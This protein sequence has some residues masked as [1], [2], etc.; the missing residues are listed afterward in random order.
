MGVAFS[1]KA[2]L[3]YGP[4]GTI[5]IWDAADPVLYSEHALERA[6][7]KGFPLLGHSDDADGLVLIHHVSPPAD[8]AFSPDGR[9]IASSAR[10]DN[11]A[12]FQVIIR[13]LVTRQEACRIATPPAA[14]RDLSFSVDGRALAVLLH[15]QSGKESKTELRIYDSNSG[16]LTWSVDGP[17]AKGTALFL[18]PF[19][20]QFEA[21][22]RV[23]D[24]ETI[25]VRHDPAT[26]REAHRVKVAAP[27]LQPL[28]FAGG[29]R[30]FGAKPQPATG[31]LQLFEFNPDSGV[32]IRCWSSGA[33]NLTARAASTRFLATSHS[34]GGPA[35]IALWDIETGRLV[36][37]L[38]GSVGTITGLAFS[39]DGERLLSC[40]T[41]FAARV[42]DT[43]SGREL[44]TLSNHGD[45]VLK[46]AWSQDGERIATASLDGAVRVWSAGGSRKLPAIEPWELLSPA[47]GT[48]LDPKQFLTV[49]LGDW[50]LE[51]DDLI[52]TLRDLKDKGFAITEAK[53]PT[54]DLPRTVDIQC[55]VEVSR[56]M[57]IAIS[58]NNPM[59]G[60]GYTPFVAGT[61]QPFGP[62]ARL[63]VS[64]KKSTQPFAL[65]G[66]ARS[67][68]LE[69]NRPYR[70]RVLRQEGRLRLFVDEQ[71]L[72]DEKVPEIDLPELS[73]QGSWSTAGDEIRFSRII[74]RAPGSAVRERKLRARLDR[75][76]AEELLPGPVRD[77]LMAEKGLR[78]SE[79]QTLLAALATLPSDA[80]A[81]RASA[82]SLATKDGAAQAE[83]ER[84]ARQ[85]KAVVEMSGIQFANPTQGSVGDL[86][87]LSLVEHRLG[88]PE[89]AAEILFPLLEFVRRRQG[90]N[91]L[92][93]LALAGLVENSRGR[94]DSAS[95][96]LQRLRDLDR[97]EAKWGDSAQPL[98][99]EA[100]LLA[101]RL[102]VLDPAREGVKEAFLQTENAGWLR[103]EIGIYFAGRTPDCIDIDQR[104]DKPG[105]HDLKLT[106]AV[107]RARRALQF[108]EV[109]PDKARFLHDDW[110]I[111][112]AGETAEMSLTSIVV[113]PNVWIGRWSIK[114][115]LK[116]IGNEWKL[117]GVQAHQT[118]QSEGG[119]LAELNRSYWSKKDQA[120]ADAKSD[121]GRLDALTDAR[122]Y[123]EAFSLGRKVVADDKATGEDWFNYSKAALNMGEAS[124][125][126]R[127]AKKAHELM[128]NQAPLPPW[129]K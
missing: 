98:V 58:L 88:H 63:L 68:P 30:L 110:D 44:L 57:L 22:Y 111:R 35:N 84:A 81:L 38:E 13:D 72:L 15:E 4:E 91:S 25:L 49:M 80:E 99:K 18:N 70:F 77:R 113:V 76:F 27:I 2:L 34:A 64:N 11:D 114:A 126:I 121:S 12:P 124:E 67:F 23:G 20:G 94:K 62:G 33:T 65:Q 127:A 37:K 17:R 119:Q 83:L 129:A 26:G 102:L 40:G 109:E 128:P 115:Q 9:R 100:Q 89:A 125:A 59:R 52:G 122:R 51:G 61:Q 96:Y 36:R 19:S 48:K 29:R 45:V 16:Q 56:S 120:V 85:L 82:R 5:R 71:E 117:T 107:Q 10:D 105:P 39:P 53:L 66:I 73:L 50:R 74:V 118:H 43:A 86:G 21:H 55:R 42:W 3:S 28:Y 104:D 79:R 54:I 14:E 1:G 106:P 112:I 103:K 8:L 60:L 69:A 92:D 6:R 90:Y 108:Q 32:E 24:A 47:A 123:Q 41:D 78:D 75:L 46:A 116:R 97:P 93:E 101:S 87:L 95:H 31:D 7:K